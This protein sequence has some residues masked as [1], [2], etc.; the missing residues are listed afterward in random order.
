M[1]IKQLEPTEIIRDEMG[2]WI[3]PEYL[4]YINS[5]ESEA[6]YFTN[7]EWMELKRFFNI[8]TVTLWLEASVSQD[9]WEIMMDS[10]DIRKWDPVAP[11]GFFLIDIGFSE[12]DAYALFAREIRKESEVA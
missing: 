7:E 1:E 4:K 2:A 3:H 11:H 6:D 9:D 5:L 8:E 10:A 12:D